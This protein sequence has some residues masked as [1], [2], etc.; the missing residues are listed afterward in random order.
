MSEPYNAVTVYTAF[1]RGPQPSKHSA[2]RLFSHTQS[3][4]VTLDRGAD[5]TNNTWNG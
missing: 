2:S 5:L 1:R 3:G 4:L